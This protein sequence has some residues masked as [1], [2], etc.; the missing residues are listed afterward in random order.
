MT[1]NRRD[2]SSTE[3]G[4]WLREQPEIDSSLGFV[5]SNIDFLWKNYH[6]G[7]WMF[8]EEKRFR[9]V[10]KF[11]QVKLYQM[12]DAACSAADGYKGFHLLIF[13]NTSPSDGAIWLDG[14][15]I[16]SCDFI[17]FLTFEN[18]NE[19][20]KSYFPKSNLLQIAA[21]KEVTQ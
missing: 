20:Y 17:K 21:P 19:W 2:N 16:T 6:S 13:E 8:I 11:Y 1:Q 7:Y 4:L 18:E 12:L 15:Y 10:P 14:R 9:Y 3:F 5:T